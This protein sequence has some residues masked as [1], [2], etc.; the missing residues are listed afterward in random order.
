MQKHG[1]SVSYAG[2]GR[3]KNK[4]SRTGITGV[5]AWGDKYRAY[6]TVD[7]KQ[8]NLGTFGKLEDAVKARKNAEE[9]YFSER[10]KQV[11]EIKREVMKKER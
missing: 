2:F 11:N 9:R 8:I 3:R 5:S 10:Q 6:I 1:L 7:R 4:N